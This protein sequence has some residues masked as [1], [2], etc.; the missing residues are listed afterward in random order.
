MLVP[1][2]VDVGF[3]EVVA[4]GGLCTFRR[5]TVCANR[6]GSL[7]RGAVGW[8]LEWEGGVVGGWV[9]P[10]VMGISRQRM[11]GMCM[12]ALVGAAGRYFL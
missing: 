11:V 7:M 8:V 6:L 3:L 5:E 2:L 9:M 12:A 10:P 1:S 4:G